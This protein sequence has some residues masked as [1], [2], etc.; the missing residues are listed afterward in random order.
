MPIS[1][2]LLYF[3]KRYGK[4]E[5]REPQISMFSFYNESP[6]QDKHMNV[7]FVRVWESMKVKTIFPVLNE[8]IISQLMLTRKDTGGSKCLLID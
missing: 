7:S 1:T 6:K 2:C 8:R 3:E 5:T 4:Y